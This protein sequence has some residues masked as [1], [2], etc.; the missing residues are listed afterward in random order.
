MNAPSFL[1][2]YLV[3]IPV[4]LLP[5][6]VLRAIS[7]LTYILL[8][9]ITGYRKKVVLQN[10]KNSFPQ[11]TIKEQEKICKDFYFHF[12]DLMLES[13]KSFTISK[14]SLKKHLYCKNPELINKYF[15]QN[16]S[17]IITVGHYNSWEF[18]LSGIDL[19][20]K[21]NAVVIYQPLTNKFFDQKIRNTR[22]GF[23]TTMVSTKVVKQFF[24]D[25]IEHPAAT[26]FAIDQSPPRPD[27]AYWMNFLNQDTGVLFGAEKYAK[28]YDLPVLYA[29]INK[30]SRGYYS[31]EFFDVSS[32]PKNTAYGEI[33]EKA[34]RLLEKDIIA[35]P[36]FW[37]WSHRRWKH[38]RPAGINFELNS[39][40]MSHEKIS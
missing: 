36:E 22:S 34:T 8:Y 24:E 33:T 40:K 12:S 35:K 32:D 39:K 11:L 37:L 18:F 10:I 29:R 13:F 7:A 25:K 30:E 6:P 3:M 15:E 5:F 26:V 16:K 2:Y 14:A 28:D 9:H 19:L 1:L 20:I 31:L 27:K 4:S 38:Q 17:V 21:H 23:G